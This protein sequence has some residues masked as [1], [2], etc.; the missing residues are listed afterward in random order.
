MA[1]GNIMVF[2]IHLG[3]TTYRQAQE[4]LHIYGK[5]GIFTQED[6]AP[7]VEAFFNSINLGGL[8]GKLVLNLAVA[9]SQINDMLSHAAE[10][11][12]QPSGA[13]RYVLDNRA[14]AALIDATV[15]A[16]TYIPSV[17]LDEE[18]VH[19][20]FGEAE[21]IELDENGGTLWSYPTIGLIIRLHD[22]E[23]SILQYHTIDFVT[24]T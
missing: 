7:T 24:R 18:M 1:D 14:N 13:H 15:I 11:R 21:T 3:T 19:H 10:A 4:S 23:K 8:S 6:K 22:S 9:E 5:T 20:R 2:D 16:I 17:R 12:L